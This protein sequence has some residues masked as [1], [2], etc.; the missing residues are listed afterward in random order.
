MRKVTIWDI[1]FWFAMIVLITYIIAKLIGIINTPEWV[2]LI[3]LISLV[4]I[5]GAF[6]QRVLGFMHITNQRTA[7]LKNNMDKAYSKL[8][9]QEKRILTLELKRK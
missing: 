1:I 3:P 8:E 5:I 4:F 2:S 7:Y 6:Y 9:D